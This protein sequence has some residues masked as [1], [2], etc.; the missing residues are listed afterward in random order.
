MAIKTL[1][2]RGWQFQLTDIDSDSKAL[3]SDKWQNVDLPHDWLIYD[4]H[5]LYRTSKGWYSKNFSVKKAGGMRYSVRFGG[6]YMDCTVF[7]NGETAGEWKYGYSTFEFDIT[8][9]LKDGENN[10]TVS[11]AHRSPNTRWYSGAGIYRNVWFKE[12]PQNHIVSDGVYFHAEKKRGNWIADIET[13]VVTDKP[14]LVRNTILDSNGTE[15]GKGQYTAEPLTGFARVGIAITD[16]RLWDIDNPYTYTLV[17]ELIDVD[18]ENVIDSESCKVG[19]REIEFDPNEGFLINGR[20]LKLNGV[21]MHHDLGALGSAVNEAALRRQFTKLK[22]MGVN[23]IRTSHNM[24]S[25]EFMALAD[26]MGFIVDSE[27]F[28]MWEMPKTSCDYSRFFKEWHEK[29]V[30]SWI[31]RDR[32]HPSVAM[33]SIGNEILDQHAGPRGAELAGELAMLARKHDP[34]KNGY[35]TQGSNFMPWEGAQRASQYLDIVGYNYAERVYDEHHKKYP[36]WCIYGSETAS[37]IQSRGI[38][39]FPESVNSTVYDDLQCSSMGNCST[40]WG[41]DIT[42][43]VIYMDR[44]KKF[45]AGTFI[46]TGWDY[47]GEPTPYSTKNS[48]FGQIDTAGFEKDSFYIYQ[49]EWTTPEKNPMIHLVPSYWDFNEGQLIDIKAYTNCAKSEVYLNGKLIGSFEHNHVNGH[50]LTGKWRVPYE[51]GELLAVGYD[52]SG[53]ILCEDRL[54][55]F[56]DPVKLTVEADKT[57][58]K[59]DG[60]DMI[61]LTIGCVDE[62]GNPVSNARNRVKVSVSGAARLM[63]MDNGDSTD[64]EQYK[65]DNRKMFSGKVLAMLASDKTAG[66][67]KVTVSSVS[68]PDETIVLRAIECEADDEICCAYKVPVSNDMADDVPVRR[69]DISVSSKIL[70]KEAPEI[71]AKARIYPENATYSDIEW[72][73]VNDSGVVSHLAEVESDGLEATIKA[74]GDGEVRLRTQCRNGKNNVE[75]ISELELEIKGVGRASVNPYDYV[76]ATYTSSENVKFFGKLGIDT[77]YSPRTP[78]GFDRVDFGK[79]GSDSFEIE[80][81]DF[82]E[83]QNFELWDGNPNESGSVKLGEWKINAKANWGQFIKTS[84]ELS[85]KIKGVHSIYFVTAGHMRFMGFQFKKAVRLGATVYASECA[86]IYGDSYKV[87]GSRVIGIGNN[88]IIDFGDVDFGADGASKI[89]I[90][91][92]TPNDINTV[93]IRLEGQGTEV[94]AVEFEKSAD[95]VE[96]TFDIERITG[97]KHLAFIFLPGSNFDFES[98]RFE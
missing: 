33:W 45:S 93:N 79:I 18:G 55:S 68:M 60:K 86:E 9:F 1:F 32:N 70:T 2:N 11:V 73:I 20:H 51:K 75:I 63:G 15:I 19:F 90:C 77:G 85:E 59:A 35:V 14:I 65:T 49:A 27:A 84:F 96:K 24:P 31:R 26:E 23:A 88:V 25:E 43:Y 74:A 38:Y 4:S 71:K 29:D 47:I 17:T 69:I 89:T 16:P 50:E 87:E 53:R 39:H 48:Y 6:V 28:D 5:N 83:G 67:I 78:F 36:H 82:S 40:G 91:G 72:M 64:Y 37:T 98:F 94:R 13:E 95:Y 10:I 54:H 58:M 66:E 61:F 42:E 22:E 21:C 3:Q 92:K 76:Y 81:S 30:A 7:V 41:A 62:N 97:E 44:D 52:E 57:L 56:T 12:Y 80:I 8:D 34:K 46:W